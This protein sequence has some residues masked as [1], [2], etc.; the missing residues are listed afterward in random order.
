VDSNALTTDSA[1][2]NTSNGIYRALA[3]PHRGKL[4]I[5]NIQ[6]R[7]FQPC[8]SPY[9]VATFQCNELLSNGPRVEEVRSLGGIPMA[10]PMK[11]RQ[12]NTSYR[13]FRTKTRESVTG[14]KWNIEA[15]L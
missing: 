4:T 13:D 6:A 15:V 1:A 10:I 2:A 7:G 5:K 8:K 12:S 14:L 9:L 3:K 11:N